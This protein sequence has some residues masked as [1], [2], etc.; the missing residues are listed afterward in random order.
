M[1]RDIPQDPRRYSTVILCQLPFG[2]ADTVK[3]QTVRMR[4]GYAQDIDSIFV[5]IFV[6]TFCRQDGFR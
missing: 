1:A 4:D 6:L 2:H 5:A 3:N